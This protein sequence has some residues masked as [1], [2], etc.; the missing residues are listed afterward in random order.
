MKI[1]AFYDR[2]ALIIALLLFAVT[3]CG[4]D[5]CQRSY[6]FASQS[7][8]GS[9]TPT[10]T[11]TATPTE[12]PDDEIG[13]ETPTPTE[14]PDETETPTATETPTPTAT[15]SSVIVALRNLSEETQSE[16]AAS[17]L[18][19][20][21]N[22][23][24]SQ[25]RDRTSG[26]WLGQIYKKKEKVEGDSL[27]S[28]ADGYTDLLEL[29]SGSDPNDSLS[30]PSGPV[31]YLTNRFV[32]RDDDYDGL[33]NEDEKLM[34]TDIEN[35]DTDEDGV[36]DG[37]E[38]MGQ[39]DPKDPNSK[40]NDADGDGLQNQYEAEMGINPQNSDSDADGLRDDLEIIVGSNPLIDD[41]DGD[42]ILDG[43]EVELGSDPTIPERRN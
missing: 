23:A 37:I 31:T 28:D 13:V 16:E 4:T 9:P 21:I 35:P 2:I 36:L 43:K 15:E 22:S 18:A 10:S 7:N 27:D 1:N 19:A 26:N 5:A 41:T 17:G 33:S 25:R 40:P 3:M 30:I 20:S 12:D 32:G 29:D 34:G 6:D 14:T 11:E 42:G 24:A 8:A 39:F 38:V